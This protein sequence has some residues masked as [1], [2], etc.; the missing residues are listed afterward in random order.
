MLFDARQEDATLTVGSDT[1]RLARLLAGKT[2][3]SP[4]DVIHQAVEDSARTAGL[5]V[6]KLDVAARLAMFDAARAIAVR[7]ARRPVLDHRS[8]DEILGYDKDGIPG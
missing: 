2:G 6:D 3:K 5:I 1:E 4:E 8:E 7:S